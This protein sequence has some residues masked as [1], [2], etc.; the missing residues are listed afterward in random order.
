MD[1]TVLKDFIRPKREFVIRLCQEDP[2]MLY[3]YMAM[4][5][6]LVTDRKVTKAQGV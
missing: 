1:L 3:S 5:V 4:M 6:L 2:S